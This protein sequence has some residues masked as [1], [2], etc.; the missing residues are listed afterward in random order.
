[1]QGDNEI[2]EAWTDQ[3]VKYQTLREL[4]KFSRVK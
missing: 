1:M 3:D 2:A 4:D